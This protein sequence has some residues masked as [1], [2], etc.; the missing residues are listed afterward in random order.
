MVW[1]RAQKAGSPG[2]KALLLLLGELANDQA[3]TYRDQTFIADILEVSR[4]T[5]SRNL[6]LLAEARLI[7][8]E[9][10]FDKAGQRRP[11]LIKLHV[12]NQHMDEVDEDAP[13]DDSSLSPCDDSSQQY[14]HSLNK[15]TSTPSGVEEAPAPPGP[16]QEALIDSPKRPRK[17]QPTHAPEWQ[18]ALWV[19]GETNGAWTKHQLAPRVRWMLRERG[20]SQRDAAILL[21]DMWLNG[22]MA[23]T[24]GNI[25]RIIDGLQR[26]DGA[27]PTKDDRIRETL[28]MSLT[29]APEPTAGALTA[30]PFQLRITS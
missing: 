28:N 10:Q 19:S 7:T 3:E 27:G 6:K 11:N 26:V 14:K 13:C 18:V 17:T 25:G 16:V 23:P 12:T 9:K 4:E 1:A 30:D 20:M 5:V 2:A 15:Q 29:P 21:R 24:Q 8:L 22:R